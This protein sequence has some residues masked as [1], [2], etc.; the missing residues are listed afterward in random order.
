MAEIRRLT[1]LNPTAN[2]D[3]V[4]YTSSTYMLVSLICTNTTAETAEV[5]AWI[6]TSTSLPSQY[7]H[8]CKNL[9]LSG[10]NTFETF[11]FALN[12][13]DSLNVRS[14]TGAVSFILNGYDQL[15]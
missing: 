6:S 11:R 8:M 1:M 4:A 7:G 5:S 12:I 13:G 9:P 10:H 3:T 14:S 2:T 15:G